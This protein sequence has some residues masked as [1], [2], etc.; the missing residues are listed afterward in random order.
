MKVL[1]TGATGF[2]GGH[3][4]ERLAVMGKDVRALVRNPT[5]AKRLKESGIEVAVGDLLDH[6]TL[7]SASRG[8]EVI[9]HCAGMVKDWGK[10]DLF[11]QANVQGTKNLLEAALRN[12]CKIVHTSSLTVLGIHRS[13][14]PVDETFPYAQ[15]PVDPYTETK[16][17]AEK[18]ALEYV[19]K[20]IPIVVVRPGFIWGPG[21]T[22][23]LPRV[24]THLKKRRLF[25][26][27]GG[28]NLLSLSYCSNVV[29]GLIAAAKSGTSGRVYHI[30]DGEKVTGKEYFCA[31][32]KLFQ[33]PPPSITV[34][35][36][37]ALAFVFLTEMQARLR[38]CDEPPPFTLYGLYLL[39]HHLETDLSRA[40]S[41]LG[42]YPRV[43]FTE[44]MK[45]MEAW[46]NG[47]VS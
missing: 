7:V 27:S 31:L 15:R 43:G 19:G 3:L 42:Y 38:R 35:F 9:Y 5:R 17:Q 25:L 45:R 22:T 1:V 41:E 37:L 14:K 32:S 20:G 29:D 23:I 33:L 21:D 34:P 44:G 47:G 26:I 36:P 8:V 2:L 10:K 12:G 11:Y 28:K 24:L 30:T 46:V 4:A 40:K 13:A 16:I 18:L 39:S 6:A